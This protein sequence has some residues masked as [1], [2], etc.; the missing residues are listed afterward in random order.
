VKLSK[1]QERLLKR[2]PVSV[3][4]RNARTARSLVKL[5]LA[6]EKDTPRPI[7]MGLSV[8]GP[9][10]EKVPPDICTRCGLD[11]SLREHEGRYIYS[12]DCCGVLV[13]SDCSVNP[14]PQQV[15]KLRHLA[16]KLGGFLADGRVLNPVVCKR[17]LAQTNLE[18]RA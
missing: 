10:F 3:S 12:C 17:C 11:P 6:I 5:G 13:C 2:L 7:G 14:H 18:E 16:G 8:H 9:W 1:A 4:W 15:S